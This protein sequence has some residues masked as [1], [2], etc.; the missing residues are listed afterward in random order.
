M[1][2]R[3]T[4][5]SRVPHPSRLRRRVGSYDPC[6]TTFFSPAFTLKPFHLCTLILWF[7]SSLFL[8]TRHSSLAT[9]SPFHFSTVPPMHFFPPPAVDCKLSTVNSHGLSLQ[10]L[11]PHL[12]GPPRP[13]ARPHQKAGD[14]HSRHRDLQHHLAISQLPP[15]ARNPQRRRL[16]RIH[17]HGCHAHLHQVQNASPARPARLRRRA[18]RRPARRTRPT[19]PRTRKV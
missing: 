2:R 14:E 6:A 1:L 9:A 16:R 15:P 7:S 12:R 17:L 13:P 18:G 5:C 11:H 4:Q 8:A 3:S 19:P 10:N